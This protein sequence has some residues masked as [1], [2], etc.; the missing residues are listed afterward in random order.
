MSNRRSNPRLDSAVMTALRAALDE[1]VLRR[2]ATG[3]DAGRPPP[4]GAVLAV[5][6]PTGRSVVPA[7][8]RQVRDE[9]GPLTDPLPMTAGTA[10]DLGSLTK[11]VGTT[12]AVLALVDRGELALDAPL[13][14]LLPAALSSAV[15]ESWLREVTCRELLL[16]RAGLWEWWPTYVSARSAD[17]AVRLVL[18]LPPRYARDE[19]RH[20]SDLGFMLLGAVVASAQPLA[21]AVGSLVLRPLG[22]DQTSYGTP[23]SVDVAAGARGDIVEQGMLASGEPW[24][25]P[26]AADAFGSWRTRVRVGEVDDCNAFHA[27]GGAAGHA[28]LFSTADDLLRW[29]E[30]VLASLQGDGPWRRE[31]VTAFLTP[32]PDRGQR[33]GFRSW[34]SRC[35]DCS[36]EAFGHPGFPGVV[37]AVL[38]AHVT[39]VVLL[40]NRLH[41]DDPQLAVATEA[42]WQPVL[43]DVHALLHDQL[44]MEV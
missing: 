38:P 36:A 3:D 18:Q 28:G 22:L 4:P 19:G 10:H 24:P 26:V 41:V 9:D 42:M 12:S 37:A 27:F 2:P 23:L 20:Y 29:G 13:S 40:T 11:V 35:G 16:H 7:G 32:G 5:A 33:L 8:W 31:V 15:E 34:E 14:A 1:H 44:L 17:D 25:V 39:V 21:D 30:A 43:D 6:G